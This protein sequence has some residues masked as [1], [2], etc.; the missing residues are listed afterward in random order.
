MK[1]LLF[2]ITLLGS[3][4]CF[5]AEIMSVYG[6]TQFDTSSVRKPNTAI[7]LYSDNSFELVRKYSE[8]ESIA[9]QSGDYSISSNSIKLVSKKTSCEREAQYVLGTF[10]L[11][12]SDLK[13]DNINITLMKVDESFLEQFKGK[14]AK[15]TF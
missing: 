13:I 11:N 15:C 5:S 14:D 9:V 1:K 6:V 4:S 2:F 12:Y 10:E 7:V 8:S 3:I